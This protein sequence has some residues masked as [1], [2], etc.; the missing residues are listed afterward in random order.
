MAK[1]SRGGKRVANP[2]TS[3]PLS[4]SKATSS[5]SINA[6]SANINLN[7]QPQ[8]S[9]NAPVVNPQNDVVQ[10][11]PNYN[12]VLTNSK[13]L[14][15]LKR[16]GKSIDAFFNGTSQEREQMVLDAVNSTDIADH[17]SNSVLQKFMAANDFRDKPQ[18][19]DTSTFNKIKGTS[20]YRTV[21]NVYDSVNDRSYS[22]QV[23]LSQLM[24]GDQTRYS[25]TGGSAY[26]RA[27]YFAKDFNES[28]LYGQSSGKSLMARFKFNDKA[29]IADDGS[30]YKEITRITRGSLSVLTPREKRIRD[31]LKK[32][33]K[34]DR[35]SVRPIYALIQGYDAYYNSNA[36]YM[37]VLSRKNMVFDKNVIDPYVNKF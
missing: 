2:K 9:V 31:I 12:A 16:R 5:A 32:V 36:G 28:R 7:A 14:S 11:T 17:L 8:S 4:A 3:T 6:T 27:L 33:E 22:P 18:V 15:I 20:Y 30:L 23:V 34:Q 1:A 19:V 24:Y 21:N 10:P 13:Y 35:Q 25:D 37:M 29:K 26:G